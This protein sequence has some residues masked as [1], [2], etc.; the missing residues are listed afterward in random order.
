MHTKIATPISLLLASLVLTAC[1]GAGKEEAPAV[2]SVK[3]QSSASFQTVTTVNGVTTFSG[4]RANYTIVKTDTGVTVTDNVGQDGVRTL[5][6]PT[7]LVFADAGVAYDL[8]G[9]AGKAYRIYQAAFNRTPDLGGLGYWMEQMDKGA[10]LDSVAGQ[11]IASAEW[12]A[13]Y[14]A[15]PSNADVLSKIYENVLHRK[16]DQAG[17]DYWLNVLNTGAASRASVLA[18]FGE[19]PENQ[20]QVAAAIA[21][22][23]SYTLYKPAEPVPAL[24]LATLTSC[25]D[26]SGSQSKNFYACMIGAM[27]GKATFGNDSC[28][29][30]MASNG[31]ITLASG[32]SKAVLQS[33]YQTAIYSKITIGSADTFFLVATAGDAASNSFDIK[34]TSPKY[35]AMSGGLT[36]G[37]QVDLKDLSCKFAL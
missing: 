36:A 27:T 35:A 28:T 6:N 14:G 8:N 29:F 32:S 15:N 23:I 11:F 13:Q 34:V 1:G 31:T 26:A 21:S 3:Q 30:T 17:Y 22:G 24:T 16:P 37:V 25:P 2:Q 19:S 5:T 4:N 33:P 9:I 10:T 7:R 20:A 12:V 18:G